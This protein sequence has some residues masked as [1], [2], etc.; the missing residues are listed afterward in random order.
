MLSLNDCDLYTHGQT[1]D[2]QYFTTLIS[3]ADPLIQHSPFK[4]NW[5]R[6]H[7]INI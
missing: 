1:G 5:F 6:K 4:I 7:L 2:S 3:K